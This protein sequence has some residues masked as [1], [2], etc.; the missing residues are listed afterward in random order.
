MHQRKPVEFTFTE[1]LYGVV[2]ATAITRID[3][4]EITQETVLLI[5]ALILV[6]DDYILYHYDVQK[7]EGTGQ[8]FVLLFACDMLVLAAWYALVLST[9][10]SMPVFF[11][12]LAIYFTATSVWELRF[13]RGSIARRLFRDGDLPLVGASL[14]LVALARSF[15]LPFWA[16]LAGFLVAFT[17]WRFPKWKG[18]WESD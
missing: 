1:L 4:L 3:A 9:T 5:G 2:I 18:I 14:S 8:N 15:D 10:Y 12:C 6:F 17:L 13:A 11:T 16:F 7:I